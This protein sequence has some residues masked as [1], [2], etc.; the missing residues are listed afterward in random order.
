[1]NTL[2]LFYG[3]FLISCGLAA[4]LFIGPKAKTALVS[5][6]S[7]GL[8]S[9]CCGYFHASHPSFVFIEL[10]ISVFLFFIFSWRAT[11]TFLVLISFIQTENKDVNLK[12]IAFLIIALMAITSLMV[13]TLQ[14]ILL[15]LPSFAL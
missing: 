13:T 10:A 5:G 2:F 15:V 12:A 14:L 11:K 8:L 1:M 9:L 6:G 4:V 3:F 7:F